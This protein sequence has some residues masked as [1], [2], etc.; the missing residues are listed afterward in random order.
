MTHADVTAISLDMTFTFCLASEQF[1]EPFFIWQD[2]KQLPLHVA[3]C[4][5][6]SDSRSIVQA[7]L[8]PTPSSMKTVPDKVRK[9]ER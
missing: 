5:T 9:L 6:G 7:L 3:C 1:C 2:K 8:K 4:R